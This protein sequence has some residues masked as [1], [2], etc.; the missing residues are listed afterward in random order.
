MAAQQ[1]ATLAQLM[2]RLGQS[3][4]GAA[5]RYQHAAS[6]RDAE[7]ARRLSSLFDREA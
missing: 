3:T 4:V 2:N 1:G 5:L 7:I 6:G